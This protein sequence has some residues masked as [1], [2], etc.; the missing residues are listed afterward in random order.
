MYI[1]LENKLPLAVLS[2][3]QLTGIYVRSC[4]HADTG[5]LWCENT[6]APEAELPAPAEEEHGG[7][8]TLGNPSSLT[9]PFRIGLG[10]CLL[11]PASSA[12]HSGGSR[13]SYLL[14]YTILEITVI[15]N[16]SMMRSCCVIS[17]KKREAK[18]SPQQEEMT[19]RHKVNTSLTN[20][21]LRKRN[22]LHQPVPI[23]ECLSHLA[24][25]SVAELQYCP[26]T[27]MQ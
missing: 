27:S 2:V 11:S 7:F 16:I 21:H 5:Y 23:M 17:A 3:L 15:R 10:A 25:K 4:S 14:R 8:S 24:I 26:S 18:K 13:S 19:I 12:V 20:F 1:S 9:A 6:Q 22:K